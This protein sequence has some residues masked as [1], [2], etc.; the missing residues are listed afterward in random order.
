VERRGRPVGTA[1][2]FLAACSDEHDAELVAAVRRCPVPLREIAVLAAGRAGAAYYRRVLQDA[3]LAA[4]DLAAHSGPAEAVRV[5][6][7]ASASGLE[8]AAV[9][10][11]DL[12]ALPQAAAVTAITRARTYL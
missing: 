4:V 7:V 8:Y 3:Q 1:L 2:R 11:P 12:R 9:F 10:V 5:G 6:A